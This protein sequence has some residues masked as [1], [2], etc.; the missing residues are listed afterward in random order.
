[1]EEEREGLEG[2]TKTGNETRGSENLGRRKGKKKKQ[3]GT[4]DMNEGKG[5]EAPNKKEEMRRK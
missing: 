1:M 2:G 3:I 5:R 4:M